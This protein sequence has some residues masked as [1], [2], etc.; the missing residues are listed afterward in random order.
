M[1]PGGMH[2]L[3]IFVVSKEDL[4]N[5]F[6]AKFRSILNTINKTLS[7]NHYLYGNPDSPDKIVLNYLTT[8]SSF[9]CKSYNVTTS[10][11]KPVEFKFQ[12]KAMKW[13]MLECKYDLDQTFPLYEGKV[14]WTLKRH[15]Q[16]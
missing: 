6:A 2:V 5:P 14:E 3:G 12:P 11:V 16:V 1:L 13:V 10:S 8:T 4:L 15:L 9:N 7:S